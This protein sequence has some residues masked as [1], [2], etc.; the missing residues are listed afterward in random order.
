MPEIITRDTSDSG[1]YVD[2][3]V[4]NQGC[5]SIRTLNLTAVDQVSSHVEAS[6]CEGVLLGHTTP[7]TFID[8]LVSYAGCDSVRTLVLSG[9][10]SYVP[11]VFSP[12][13]DGINDHFTILPFP[14]NSLSLQYFAIFDRFGGMTYETTEWPMEW[15]GN[16]KSNEP[17]QPGVY[18]YVLIYQC[19]DRQTI[20][21]GDITL[22]K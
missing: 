5:D 19:G 9:G 2:T 13:N 21:H 17:Y 14:E 22:I 10:S 8:T 12:N 20:E 11:N 18:A 4:S 6:V 15:D 3:L 1:I 7:G 16:D